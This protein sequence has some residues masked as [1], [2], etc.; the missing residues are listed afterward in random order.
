MGIPDFIE[1]NQSTI[2]ER[3]KQA[4]QERLGL[5][6]DASQLLDHLPYFVADLIATLRSPS[7]QWQQMP[8][9]RG[10]GGQRMRLGIDI[11]TLT[12]EMSLVGEVV[13]ELADERQVQFAAAE[14]QRLFRAMGRGAAAS[15][16]AY[17][18][19]RDREMVE[20]AARH[21]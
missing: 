9:A 14:V 7:G 13:L 16:R 15:V 19:L 8:G 6:L 12:E 17:A 21:Y 11:G 10:P 20:Q 2:L 18:S 1:S 4:A 3:W 5:E